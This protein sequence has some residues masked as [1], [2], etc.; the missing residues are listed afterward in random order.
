MTVSRVV[1]SIGVAAS[2]AI[3]AVSTT[4]CCKKLGMN[5]TSWDTVETTGDAVVEVRTMGP[6]GKPLPGTVRNGPG[7]SFAKVGSLEN[8]TAVTV[9]SNQKADDGYWSKVHWSV[10]GGGEG[11]MHQDILNKSGGGTKPTPQPA[12]GS[13]HA[14]SESE[15]KPILGPRLK[16]GSLVAHQ[17]FQ[18]PFGPTA[19]SVFT[20]YKLND[21][22]HGIVVSNGKGWSS[23]NLGESTYVAEQI[24][25]V[26]FMDVD[27]DGADEAIVLATFTTGVGSV[28]AAFPSNAV[29]KWT[30]TEVKRLGWAEKKIE[31]MTTAAECRQ[32]LRR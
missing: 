16:V 28:R 2:L 1:R 25:A 30:G 26:T 10:N 22:F 13:Y 23:P 9:L 11:W 8:G 27:G 20:V 5:K 6:N 31:T 21:Q 24:P 32:A 17:V 14:L 3:F 15:F 29:L 18:G 19:D 12:S 4:G 7:Q